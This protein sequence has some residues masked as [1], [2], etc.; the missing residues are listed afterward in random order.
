[1]TVRSSDSDAIS[2]ESPENATDLIYPPWPS[3]VRTFFLIVAF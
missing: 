3:S 2:F 1:L